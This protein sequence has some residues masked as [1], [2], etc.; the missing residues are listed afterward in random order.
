MHKAA[1]WIKTS[2]LKK[3]ESEEFAI[4]LMKITVRQLNLMNIVINVFDRWHRPTPPR[5][6]TCQAWVSISF[7]FLLAI[8]SLF[9]FRNSIDSRTQETVACTHTPQLVGISTAS[10]VCS[11]HSLLRK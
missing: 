11:N 7:P 10:L 3:R 9:F 4:L 5:R 8:L 1:K 6:P 2:G